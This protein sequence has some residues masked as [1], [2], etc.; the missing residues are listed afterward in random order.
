MFSLPQRTITADSASDSNKEMLMD[1]ASDEVPIDISENNHTSEEW[2]HLLSFLF[3]SWT[4]QERSLESL[5][6]ILNLG[7][8]YQIAEAREYAIQTL[9]VRPDFR[10]ALRLSLT[11][12]NRILQWIEPAVHQLFKSSLA[13]L[14]DIDAHLI[15]PEILLEVARTQ[16]KIDLHRKHLALSPP[17]VVHSTYLCDDPKE[18]S[19]AWNAAWWG[20]HDRP[21]V[22]K[23]LLQPQKPIPG[24]EIGER[25]QAI[26]VSGMTFSCKALTLQHLRQ[27]LIMERLAAEDKLINA[28]V[29]SLYKHL[30]NAM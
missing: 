12:H 18:C 30:E 5:I 26:N 19:R 15:G 22:A 2:D 1:G 3:P 7:S 29:D 17:K 10:P 4:A 6:A 25:L 11:R 20:E 16:A 23:A 8:F 21:G 27:P 28:V 9:N 13:D 14:S 24:R